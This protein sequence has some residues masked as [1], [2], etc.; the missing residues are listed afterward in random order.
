V[1][2]RRTSASA[3]AATSPSASSSLPLARVST[4]FARQPE[5]PRYQWPV[6]VLHSARDWQLDC[7]IQCDGG[8]RM[9]DSLSELIRRVLREAPFAMRQLASDAGL[10]YDVLRSWRSGRRRP[11]RS[12]AARLAA[13]LQDRGE[14]LLLL[15]RELREA[16]ESEATERGGSDQP[17]AERPQADR[18][19]PDRTASEQPASEQ[20]AP[21]QPASERAASHRPAWDEAPSERRPPDW[22]PSD[23]PM[24]DRSVSDRSEG[25]TSSGRDRE[26]GGSTPGWAPPT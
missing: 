8:C 2:S 25:S 3:P 24:S 7:A 22:R 20:P 15:A 12:S 4:P 23:R 18:S 17:G 11:S 5:H 16:T 21:E 6:Q 9:A 19:A 14:R 1:P 26:G 13:G 10:S